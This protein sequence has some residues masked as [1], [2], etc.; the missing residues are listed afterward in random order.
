[1]PPTSNGFLEAIKNTDVDWAF[2]LPVIIDELSKDAA[3]VDLVASKLNHLFYTGG[4]LPSSSGNML[5]SRIP[6]YQVMGSSECATFPLLRAENDRTSQTWNYIQVHPSVQAEFRHRFEDL[7]EL[8]VVKKPDFELYQPVF[9]HFPELKEYETRDLFSPHPTRPELWTH[10]SRIDDVI[11]FI[12]GEKTNPISFEQEVSR[13][14]EV[15][16][17]LVAGQQ[18]FEASLLVELVDD[19]VLSSDEQAK[20]VERIWPSVQKANSQCPAHAKVSKSKILF[21]DPSMPMPR[22]GKGTVQRQATWKLYSKQLDDLYNETDSNTSGIQ[23]G[24]TD[25][26]NKDSL[27]QVVHELVAGVTEWK[28]FDDEDEFFSLGMDSLQVLRL[29]RELKVRF[30]LATITMTTVYTN[31]SVSLLT[32]EIMKAA[33]QDHISA[34]DSEKL[35]LSTMAALLQNYHNNIDE[36]AATTLNGS[37]TTT[38]LPSTS[39]VIVLTGS[40]GAVGS[41]ILQELLLK[42]SV[43]HVYCLNRAANSQSIQTA[44]NAKRRLPTDFSPSRVTF[45]TADLSKPNFGLPTSVY[46]KILST[47]TQVIH[48]AWPI[49]FNRTLQ[50]FQTSLDG[51]VNLISFAAKANL[52]PSIFFL[53]SISS[54]INYHNTSNA[55]TLIPEA[56]ITDLSCAAP[57]GYGESKYLAER[58]LDY[59]AHK[60][61][62]NTGT[63]RIGQIAGTAREPHGWNRNE[64]LPSLVVS[65][66]YIGALP[67]SLGSNGSGGQC[68]MMDEIDWVPIDQLARVLVELAF[69]LHRED[70]SSSLRV[71]HATHP[72]PTSWQNLLPTVRES[73]NGSFPSQNRRTATEIK[74]LSFQA[75]V[76]L[77]R[78]KSLGVTDDDTSAVTPEA[79]QVNP[80]MKLLGF[81]ERLLVSD[82]VGTRIKMDTRQTLQVSESLRNLET[83]R[84]EWMTG[85][86]RDWMSSSK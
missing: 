56:V 15:R 16:A 64:W 62:L 34:D 28:Q 11:V 76:D 9:L 19:T 47:T 51:V 73:L 60:L 27:T 54:V 31:P 57:M 77:L 52:S 14:P 38:R 2:L 81:Y 20:A 12:N 35:R 5:S 63:A 40:T 58:M 59:A 36:L 22:A 3:S 48:N 71:F 1:M 49:D 55:E 85:W 43:A 33:S 8:V 7:Y 26:A 39:H 17:A 67:E 42:E 44:R 21:V 65:S 70:G 69:V 74:T 53:S 84:P 80:G 30:G 50:S 41:Y 24:R 29:R 82:Q 68:G 75:W 32:K 86:I 37:T 79:V 25:L 72:H 13:H 66:R 46:S 45:L 4:S 10:R 61:H 6:V 78:S 83:L 18:R 23:P